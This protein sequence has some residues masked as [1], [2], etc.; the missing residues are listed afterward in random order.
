MF[1][2]SATPVKFCVLLALFAFCLAWEAVALVRA[3][4]AVGRTSSAAHLVMSVVML[5]MVPRSWWMP[6]HMHL[7]PLPLLIGLM[8][9]GAA[10]FA[11]RTAK[12]APGHRT[13]PATCLAMFV[14][15]VWHLW[16]MQAMMAHT[17]AMSMPSHGGMD[18]S[19]MDHS[20][21]AGHASM[22]GMAAKSW[23]QAASEPGHLLWWVAVAGVVLLAVMLWAT[24]R[25]LSRIPGHP[26][27]RL[28]LAAEA[29]MCFGMAWMST[30]LL[31]PVAPWVHVLSF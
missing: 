25:A 10:W 3:R 31:T 5:A 14:T 7:A 6:F 28:A 12:A 18:H 29:A 9:L 26:G 22:G 15:M 19:Q 23:Q 13:H 4:G 17:M 11:W 1:T 30:G 2:L 20:H 24:T 8:A 27:Q 16:A 21:M